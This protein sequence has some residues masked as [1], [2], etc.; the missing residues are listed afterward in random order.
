MADFREIDQI[1]ASIRA[2]QNRLIRG[3]KRVFGLTG[4]HRAE[5]GRL[6]FRRCPTG[7]SSHFPGYLEA[8][9]FFLNNYA[10]F[11]YKQKNGA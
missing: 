6:S 11:L 5:G 10:A 1:P 9:M 7:I 2:P 8:I 3:K 4:P